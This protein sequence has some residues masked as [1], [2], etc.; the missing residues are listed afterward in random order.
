MQCEAIS[1]EQAERLTGLPSGLIKALV[2]SGELPAEIQG[3]E[4]YVSRAELLGW[5]RVF[6]KILTAAV[7]KHSRDHVS[8][9]LSAR[10]LVWL[11][12]AGFLTGKERIRL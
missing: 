10:N 5:C 9:G 4:T 2:E 7:N 6:S 3:R 1:L 8:A 12:Q 11:T